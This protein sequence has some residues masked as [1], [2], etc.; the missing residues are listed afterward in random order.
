MASSKSLHFQT[1]RPCFLPRNP[2][3]DVRRAVQ[4]F[5]APLFKVHQQLHD[6]EIDKCYFLEIQRTAVIT[7]NF[8]QKRLPVTRNKLTRKTKRR[9]TTYRSFLDSSR[10]P[11]IRRLAQSK[12]T[13]VDC[14]N[15]RF[16]TSQR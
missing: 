11:L 6:A 12:M 10:H 5:D 13:N 16:G 15:S 2:F 14:V 8:F 4:Q 7:L 9:L 1:A 3:P